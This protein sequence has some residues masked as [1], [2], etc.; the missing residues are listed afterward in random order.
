MN[1]KRK[2]I[3]DVPAEAFWS[4][5]VYDA[6]GFPQGEVYNVN[7]E[8]AVPEKDG[9]V[10]IHFGGDKSAAN[11]I[12]IYDTWNMVLRLYEST[13]AYFNGEWVRPELELVE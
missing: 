2:H 7:S 3:K 8:F 1:P 11:Y 10:I 5:T 4:V 6:E 12:D 9:S 13:E